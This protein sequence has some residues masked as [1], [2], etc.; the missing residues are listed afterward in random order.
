MS[1]AAG[2]AAAAAAAAPSAAAAAA[3]APSLGEPPARRSTPRGA[4]GSAQQAAE[5]LALT[6]A[7]AAADTLYR[8][9]PSDVEEEDGAHLP[10]G[11]SHLRAGRRGRSR[12]LPRAAAPKG[13]PQSTPDNRLFRQGCQL[14]AAQSAPPRA[15]AAE[16][17]AAQ[18]LL[19]PEAAAPG[20]PPPLPRAHFF[21]VNLV[22]RGVLAFYEATA[23]DEPDDGY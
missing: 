10:P 18:A 23:E 14:A 20:P 17:A 16:A 6:R 12:S 21:N 1:G 5:D 8:A 11:F 2:A 7:A 4:W 13:P 19:A 3:K 22:M 9:R 15:R